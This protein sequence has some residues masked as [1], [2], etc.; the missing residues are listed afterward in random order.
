M[1]RPRPVTT[2]TTPTARSASGTK[3]LTSVDFPTPEWPTSTLRLP[4][5]RSAQLVQAVGAG[6][7]SC[8]HHV[9]DRQ[10]GVLLEEGCGVGEVR[11]GEHEDRLHPGVV[12]RDE[13]PVDEPRAGLGVGQGR[14]DDELVGV[15]DENP[16]DGV[17]VVSGSA[18]DR[19]RGERRTMRARLPSE[20]ELSPTTWT[21]SPTTIPLRPSSRARIAMTTRREPAS[22]TSVVYRPRSTCVTR[23]GTA[24]A[25]VG[26]SLLRGRDPRR[27]G[28]IRTSDSS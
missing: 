13:A 1:C 4:D 26:R 5:E 2:L 11:L 8:G 7:P 23:A 3:A 27:L 15:G 22:S 6:L 17:G 9:S 18:Q 21:R 20:P 25:C 28:R 19:L 24:S 14:D 16:L 12:C 10:R